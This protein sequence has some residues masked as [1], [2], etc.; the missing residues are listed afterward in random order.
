MPSVAPVPDLPAQL[1]LDVERGPLVAW[2]GSSPSPS[3]SGASRASASN[4]SRCLA[5]RRGDADRRVPAAGDLPAVTMRR[6][7]AAALQVRE[8]PATLALIVGQRAHTALPGREW[9]A[10]RRQSHA[11]PRTHPPRGHRRAAAAARPHTP[12]GPARDDAQAPTPESHRAAQRPGPCQQTPR[13]HR[14]LVS[15]Q[16]LDD[17]ERE[18]ALSRGG[19]LLLREPCRMPL[20]SEK[21][22]D[23]VS[24]FGSRGLP[25]RSR[26]YCPI[27][28]W[29][30]GC[31]QNRSA[32]TPAGCRCRRAICCAGPG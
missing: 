22:S 1:L 10:D 13:R 20:L 19:E 25:E 16:K 6:R 8:L 3:R 32:A 5:S 4:S 9:A 14:R 28:R 29:R 15:S 26:F 12:P 27:G 31:R 23:P 30:I 11:G 17:A 7:I 2:R 24:I 18:R 21:P